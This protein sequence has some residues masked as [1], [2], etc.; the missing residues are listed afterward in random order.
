MIIYL[1]FRAGADES[2]LNYVA[3]HF[4]ASMVDYE[5]WGAFATCLLRA[6][7]PRTASASIWFPPP[8]TIR[9][10]PT[11]GYSSIA[12][13]TH[14]GRPSSSL[15]S[16]LVLLMPWRSTRVRRDGGDL[17]E[18]VYRLDC[19]PTR[20]SKYFLPAFPPMK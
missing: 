8:V 7:Q 4:I 20:T 11:K 3:N 13:S 17:L 2:S 9:T 5:L 1:Q 15:F 19:S 18:V 14:K 12:S 16:A 10:V 6:I